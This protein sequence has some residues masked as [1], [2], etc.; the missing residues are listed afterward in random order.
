M[1]S[2]T[3][4]HSHTL[5]YVFFTC[6]KLNIMKTNNN[7]DMFELTFYGNLNRLDVVWNFWA[8]ATSTSH[9]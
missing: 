5:T 2:W 3:L 1:N 6:K 8:A 7:E 9:N 4:T